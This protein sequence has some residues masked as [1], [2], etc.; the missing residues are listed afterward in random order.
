VTGAVFRDTVRFTGELDA[1]TLTVQKIFNGNKYKTTKYKYKYKYLGSK[2]KYKYIK[3]YLSTS[4]S[5][6]YAISA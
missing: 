6:K 3:M 2:Y 5:T 1:G 4:T